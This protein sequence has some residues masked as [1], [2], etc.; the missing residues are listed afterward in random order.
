M[1]GQVLT[2]DG[3]ADACSRRGRR[4]PSTDAVDKPDRV[5]VDLGNGIAARLLRDLV[6]RKGGQA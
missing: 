6:K 4:A 5:G 1:T 3:R 2:V